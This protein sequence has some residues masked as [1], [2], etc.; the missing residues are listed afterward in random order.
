MNKKIFC[1]GTLPQGRETTPLWKLRHWEK[2]LGEKRWHFLMPPLLWNRQPLLSVSNV[3]TF[4]Q[5]RKKVVLLCKQ[6]STVV[7]HPR[8]TNANHHWRFNQKP[9]SLQ[10][11]RQQPIWGSCSQ[12]WWRQRP[13]RGS[14]SQQWWRQR[15]IRGSCSQQWWRTWQWWT[16]QDCGSLEESQDRQSSGMSCVSFSHC[17]TGQTYYPT[18]RHFRQQTAAIYET[19]T[20]PKTYQ[21]KKSFMTAEIVSEGSHR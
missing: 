17:T 12:R 18:Y 11:W 2:L 15:P 5:K 20:E 9:T 4:G 21:Q 19:F 13:I 7:F 16:W 8:N 1:L 14:C 6:S 3:P 10:W